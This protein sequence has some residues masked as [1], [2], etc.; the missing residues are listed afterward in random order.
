LLFPVARLYTSGFYFLDF[1]RTAVPQLTLK[2]G[3]VLNQVI[4]HGDENM[5]SPEI[6]E[7]A[8]ILVEKVGD[9]AIKSCDRRFQANAPSPA[10]K[11]WK[12][13]ARDGY[14]GTVRGLCSRS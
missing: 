14:E 9:A 2:S 3:S 4:L 13:M 8:G 10:A 7:F 12:E 5:P 1:G 6:E 11:R